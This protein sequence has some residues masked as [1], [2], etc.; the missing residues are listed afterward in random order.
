M[1]EVL[2]GI[3]KGLHDEHEATLGVMKA[4]TARLDALECLM[5]GVTGM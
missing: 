4:N 2:A 5:K 3:E 1:N